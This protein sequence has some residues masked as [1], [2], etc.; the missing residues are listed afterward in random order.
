MILPHLLL[1]RMVSGRFYLMIKELKIRT[2]R[3]PGIILLL[4]IIGKMA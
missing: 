1:M 4:P 2:L 3:W